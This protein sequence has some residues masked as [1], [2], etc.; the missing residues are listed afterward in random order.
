[1][2][3]LAQESIDLLRQMVRTPSPSFGEED[4]CALIAAALKGWGIDCRTVGRNILAFN[5]RYD[6]SL[7]TLVLDAHIDTVPAAASYTRDPLDP[8]TDEEIVY[9]LGSNDDGGSVVSMIAAFRHFYDKPMPI[10]IAL[11]LSC[12]EERSGPDG[13]R[14]L[15]S[16]E[17]PLCPGKAQWV[18]I[19]EPTGMR[20]ATS[21]RGLL[22][23]DC[24]A[25]G[26]SGHAARGEGVN[27]LYIAMEDIAALRAHKFTRI[28]PKTGEVRLMVT[29]IAAGTAHN[30]VPD[31]CTFVVDIRPNELYTNEEIVE[32]LQAIC[33]ST[34]KARNLT[35]RSSATYDGSPLEKTALALGVET[36]SS[37][38]TSNWMR[39]GRDA[40]KMGPGDSSRSHR[41]NEY[42]LCSE[43]VDAVEKYIKFVE[44][45]YGNTME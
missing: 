8:G 37:P 30:V 32:E 25:Q 22:V 18:I 7:P 34:L 26:V 21:E 28:S 16:P 45:F 36:F 43:I 42:I 29:Q 20:A 41:A 44:N 31:K 1:M 6:E 12:E 40:I 10:N 5:S 19:G 14:F 24:E 27:A 15:Y 11:A 4:V 13:A 39:T 38:T 35:N 33:R 3:K 23:L 9:G 2:T 17:G